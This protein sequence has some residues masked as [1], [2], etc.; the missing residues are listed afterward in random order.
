[1]RDKTEY[2][3][4]GRQALKALLDPADNPVD[5][6][7]YN[8][9]DNNGTWQK[10]LETGP[11]PQLRDLIP[12]SSTDARMAVVLGDVSGDLYDIVWWADSMQKAGQSLRD[13]RAFLAGRDQP[14]NASL[15][16]PVPCPP[17]GDCRN[18][19]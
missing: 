12:L 13:M 19:C 15:V 5:Q 16:D 2:L 3:E 8:F 1:M 4:I 14:L 6:F 17:G 18:S 9:L 7:R 10:A 11:S